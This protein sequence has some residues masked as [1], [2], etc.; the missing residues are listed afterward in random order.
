GVVPGGGYGVTVNN[1]TLSAKTG[2]IT[3]TGV[4]QGTPS[5]G[6]T[7]GI[8][9]YNTV[10]F[11]SLNNRLNGEQ[12]SQESW[13]NSAGVL[14]GPGSNIVFDGNTTID[15]TGYNLAGLLFNGGGYAGKDINVSFINGAAD[16]NGVLKDT[17]ESGIW[18]GGVAM[19]L[20]DGVEHQKVNIA[21][22]NASLNITGQA[23]YNNGIATSRETGWSWSGYV[24]SGNGAINVTGK[25]E[26]AAGI[27][28]NMLNNLNMTGCLTL[29][30]VSSTGS[31]VT[32][33]SENNVSISNATIK[34]TSEK[35][36]GIYVVAT[37]MYDSYGVKGKSDVNLHGNTLVGTSDTGA[38]INIY[39][40]NVTITNGSLNGTS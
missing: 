28:I 21:A 14:I 27:Q 8:N 32:I 6:F 11:H 38:G 3:V 18:A 16:V 15:A 36:D 20:W 4:A 22:N 10:N 31:G 9:I 12:T 19:F 37:G 26:S 13:V 33:S 1:A 39:G 7:A 34:G 25:S 5:S 30:G 17:R 24:F 29:N 2:N 35:G 40:E 23:S